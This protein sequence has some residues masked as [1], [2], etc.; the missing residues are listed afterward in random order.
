M[1]GRAYVVVDG[2][3]SFH[4]GETKIEKICY[5]CILIRGDLFWTGWRG[6]MMINELFCIIQ[7]YFRF[8]LRVP[9]FVIVVL[10][11]PLRAQ[12][13]LRADSLRPLL[14]RPDDPVRVDIINQY[15][16]QIREGDNVDAMAWAVKAHDLSLKL[17][18]KKGLAGALANMGWINYRQGDFPSAL[19]LTTQSLAISESIKDY[20][21]MASGFNN[22]ASI[23]VEQKEYVVALTTFKKAL[24]WGKKAGNE[25]TAGRSY[26]N[27]AYVFFLLNILDSARFYALKG[28]DETRG[29]SAGFAW[30]TLG[31][32]CE[33]ENK[34]KEAEEIYLKTL[35]IAD[36][37]KNYSL[38]VST[39]HRLGKMYLNHDQILQAEKV[40][41]ENE[42]LCRRFRFRNELANTYKVL[43]DLYRRKSDLV[44]GIFYQEKF[45]SLN[46]SLYNESRSK[47]IALLE[48]KY[49]EAKID[50][51]TKESE[52]RAKEIRAEKLRAYIA[53]GG[54]I[55]FVAF[56]FLL[57][58]NN[59]KMKLVNRELA[60]KNNEITE[61]GTELKSQAEALARLNVTKDKLFSIISHDLR[62]P[63]NSLTGLLELSEKGYLNEEEFKKYVS[64]LSKNT[65]R[66]KELLDN[67]LYWSSSQLKK[68]DAQ[69]VYFNI[70]TAI[71]SVVL[72][73]EKQAIAKNIKI[74]RPDT[75]QEVWADPNMINLV[76][77]NLFSNAIK[78]S[79]AGGSVTIG[80]Q[81]QEQYLHCFLKDEGV[82]ISKDL[83][84]KLFSGEMITTRGTG[85][86]IGTGLGLQLCIDF[87]QRNR[88]RFWV[89]SEPNK[90][91]TFWFTLPLAPLKS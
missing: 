84:D 42:K 27:I 56:A 77:R 46:D 8:F 6:E 11:Y 87:I 37:N 83:S 15:V 60:E 45:T 30:R 16:V 38:R 26:N 68:Q 57:Y 32:V 63:L 25:Y 79:K 69:P 80:Y 86:E 62:G 76:L 29:Y 81:S 47:Q 35:A 66:T 78:F 52:L 49:N 90:G 5:A 39:A 14:N 7:M 88:G 10:A 34:I 19:E 82:G 44:K 54:L 2:F 91:S 1:P 23:Y 40:L 70:R 85:N 89:D 28:I 17:D 61:R 24:A 64:E 71:D 67:L 73:Y 12:T 75:D 20:T 50:L 74:V 31:D 33:K 18:Y 36:V 41:L 13:L 51:L 21:E 43:G 48:R 72:L 9:I 65:N 3:F 59:Q 58:A 22:L 53:V 55:V 4:F